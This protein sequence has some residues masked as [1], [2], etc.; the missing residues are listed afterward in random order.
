MEPQGLGD[1][2]LVCLLESTRPTQ[3]PASSLLLLQSLCFQNTSQEWHGPSWSRCCSLAPHPA[4]E[5]LS[6]CPPPRPSLGRPTNLPLNP[7]RLLPTGLSHACPAP[8][9]SVQTIASL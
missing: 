1:P 6:A 9:D 2:R 4:H 7:G 5:M 8:A 3:E